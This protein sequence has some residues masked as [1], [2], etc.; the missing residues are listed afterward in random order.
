M[1]IFIPNDSGHGGFHT[2][3]FVHVFTC[4]NV[5]L[6]SASLFS[7]QQQNDDLLKWSPFSEIDLLDDDDCCIDTTSS[8]ESHYFGPNASMPPLRFHRDVN[9]VP[10]KSPYGLVQEILFHDPWKLLIA[11]IFLNKTTGKEYKNDDVKAW[12]CFLHYWPF[13]WGIHGS[14]VHYPHKGPII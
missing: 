11:T 10:P 12:K 7:F 3:M 13:V 6:G 8:S 14:L 4:L 2:T 1:F 9:W 5:F